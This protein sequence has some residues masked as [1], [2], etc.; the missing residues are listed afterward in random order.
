MCGGLIKEQICQNPGTDA[1]IPATDPDCDG[2]IAA[3]MTTGTFEYQCPVGSDG[4]R[5]AISH[6]VKYGCNGGKGLKY[7]LENSVVVTSQCDCS[8]SCG[9][10]G[11]CDD[12][13]K[14]G[15]LELLDTV[16]LVFD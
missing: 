8:S 1:Y 11:T 7:E 10:P 13:S 6:Y 4:K 5:H 14:G 2:L 9:K 16:T 15:K 12:F 3:T